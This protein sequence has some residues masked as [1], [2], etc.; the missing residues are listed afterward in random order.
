MSSFWHNFRSYRRLC[1]GKNSEERARLRMM[2]R[3][4]PLSLGFAMAQQMKILFADG[5]SFLPPENR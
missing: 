1:S 2:I 3:S 5:I 4:G